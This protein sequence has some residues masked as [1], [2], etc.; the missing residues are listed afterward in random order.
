MHTYTHMLTC[1]PLPLPP[2]S[3]RKQMDELRAAWEKNVE[4][5]SAAG[6]VEARPLSTRAEEEGAWVSCQ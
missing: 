2:N 1:L 3:T 4:A 6:V 5:E